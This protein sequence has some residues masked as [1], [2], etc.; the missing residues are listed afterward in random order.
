MAKHINTPSH[1]PEATDTLQDLPT[2]NDQVQAV[3]DSWLDP[4]CPIVLWGFATV[5]ILGFLVGKIRYKQN[6]SAEIDYSFW[7]PWE[8][9]TRDIDAIKTLKEK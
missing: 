8:K 1:I 7:R 3:L 6:K 4:S 9:F 2:T 5:V